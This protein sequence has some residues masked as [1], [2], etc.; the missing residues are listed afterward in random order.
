[1]DTR[2]P[3]DKKNW[4]AV[5]VR[6]VSYIQ[7]YTPAANDG[8]LRLLLHGEP[9]QSVSTTRIRIAPKILPVT[10]LSSAGTKILGLDGS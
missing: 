9:D 6:S 5:P 7:F 3:S 8:A 1:V 2:V 4:D 10:P